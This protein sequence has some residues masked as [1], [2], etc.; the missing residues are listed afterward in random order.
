M[1]TESTA[2]PKAKRASRASGARKPVAKSTK[3]ANAGTKAKGPAKPGA[4]AKPGASKPVKLL[5]CGDPQIVRADGDAPVLA[6]LR[7]R[8]RATGKAASRLIDQRIRDLGGWRGET[9]ARMRALILEADPEMAEEWKWMGT[10]VWSHNGIV[11]TGEAYTKVVKLTF[12]RGAR[13]P[14]PSRLFNSSLEGK[15][16]RAIDIHEG[17]KVDAGA[18]KS[19]VKA[20]VAQNGPPATKAKPGASAAKPVRLLAGGNPQIAKADGDAPVQAYIAAMP[21]WKRNLGERLDALIVRNVPNVRKAVKWNSPFYG[22]E[23][24]GWF[25]GFHTFTRYVKVAFFRGA[26]LRPLPP[27]PSKDKD[28]RYID[29]HEGDKLDEAQMATWVQQAA[30][31][32]GWVP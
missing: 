10:P 11:C 1:M 28:T 26:S 9:L 25:L 23:G 3:T 19:L 5:A 8:E 31:L 22:I 30:A 20:A 29:L 16:R 15:T 18:F 32:P 12:A 21:G 6:G 14:D 2:K 4:K 13:I 27:G 7:S 24:Q 17:E